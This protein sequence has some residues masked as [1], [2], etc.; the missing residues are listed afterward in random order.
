MFFDYALLVDNLT[1]V[2]GLQLYLTDLNNG[3]DSQSYYLTLK[4]YKIVIYNGGGPD[5]FLYMPYSLVNT[6]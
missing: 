5:Y 1:Y 4:K 6:P 3:D 2:V